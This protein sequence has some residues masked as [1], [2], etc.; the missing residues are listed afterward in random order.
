MQNNGDLMLLLAYLL[1]LN[2]EWN[3]ALITVRSVVENEIERDSLADSLNKLVPA[4]RINAE[5]EVIV[6]P[7]DKTVV[8]IMHS[9]SSNSDAVFLGLMEP[10][11]GR[12]SEYAERLTEL[13][14]GFHTS[15]FVHNAGE[16]AG[17][18]I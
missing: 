15:I 10:E 18:L 9:Y 6:K 13:A 1:S 8:E 5:T 14:S 4:T 7:P 2:P 17:H 3:D 12:E 11:P 16:F